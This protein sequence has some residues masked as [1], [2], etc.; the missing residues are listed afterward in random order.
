MRERIIKIMEDNNLTPSAFAD[1]LGIGRAV[2][3][4]ILTG[5]NNASIDVVV[6]ILERMSTIDSEWLL[7]GRGNMYKQDKASYNK[8]N[9][10]KQQAS[11]FGEQQFNHSIEAPQS[12]SG[13][14]SNTIE[15]NQATVHQEPD[16][17]DQTT[18]DAPNQ[19]IIAPVANTIVKTVTK[20]V[21]K[22]IIYYTDNTF[23][24]FNPDNTPL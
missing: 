5:R 14:Q 13:I 9:E 15:T 11:L 17:I 23:Q 2:M 7:F 1:R 20:N 18:K 4:H 10:G 24:A 21:S 3:S 6:R 16:V 19:E 8:G 12:S 22:I